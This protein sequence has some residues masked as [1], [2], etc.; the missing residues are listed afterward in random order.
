MQTLALE[1]LTLDEYLSN[2][3]LTR[4]TNPFIVEMRELQESNQTGV[5]KIP[6]TKADLF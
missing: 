1:S 3:D 5:S 4:D 2:Q 6:L